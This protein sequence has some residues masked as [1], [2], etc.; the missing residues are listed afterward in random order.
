MKKSSIFVPTTLRSVIKSRAAIK[1]LFGYQY[2]AA[3]IVN[4][5]ENDERKMSSLPA[6]SIPQPKEP[7]QH[8]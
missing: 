8:S 5:I 4:D 1:G 6:P 3:L 7:E 2:L